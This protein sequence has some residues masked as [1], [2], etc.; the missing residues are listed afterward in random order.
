MSAKRKNHI[1][2]ANCRQ[3]TAEIPPGL[4]WCKISALRLISLSG[5][6]DFDKYAT[7]GKWCRSV[8]GAGLMQDPDKLA[9][10]AKD[11]GYP[12]PPNS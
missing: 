12:M 5:P 1:E 8:A 4:E 6:E 11:A 2:C 10:L 7:W 3:Q 9:W